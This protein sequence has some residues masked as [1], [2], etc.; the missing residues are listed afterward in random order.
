MARPFPSFDDRKARVVQ[1]HSSG[2]GGRP[3][4]LHG[5]ARGLRL[6]CCYD[7]VFLSFSCSCS[8]QVGYVCT[9]TCVHAPR[10]HGCIHHER[11]YM[12]VCVQYDCGPL[13]LCA[14]PV[15]VL[16]RESRHASE[17]TH[18]HTTTLFCCQKIHNSWNV[19]EIPTITLGH[20]GLVR[21]YGLS[22]IHQCM[23][24]AGQS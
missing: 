21:R 17:Y 4:V 13:I 11:V 18:V 15:S 19:V 8:D 20:H 9:H 2:L 14:L 6:D 1:G 23:L 10:A 3:T 5:E 16:A 22:R 12:H 24:G 7:L